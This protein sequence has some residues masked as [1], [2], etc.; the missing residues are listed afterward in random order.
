MLCLQYIENRIKKKDNSF[1]QD[2]YT[3][4]LI[5]FIR[6]ES[7]SRICRS[8]RIFSPNVF[9]TSYLTYLL[10]ARCASLL[11]TC[12]NS[13][14]FLTRNFFGSS[15]MLPILLNKCVKSS[16]SFRSCA[17]V[18]S[19][20]LFRLFDEYQTCLVDTRSTSHRVKTFK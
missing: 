12:L 17:V 4:P 2:D 9:L 15:F 11:L 19:S 3:R 8:T 7:K 13:V 20:F 16:L 1:D 18:S 6:S 14:F 10:N 5:C